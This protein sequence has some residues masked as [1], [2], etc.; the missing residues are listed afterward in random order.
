MNDTQ[1]THDF[2]EFLMKNYAVRLEMTKEDANLFE[3]RYPDL[4]AKM[5]RKMTEEEFIQEYCIPCIAHNDEENLL[6]GKE[7]SYYKMCFEKRGMKYE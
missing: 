3:Q 4:A 7:C 2:L 1:L 5:N 6:I